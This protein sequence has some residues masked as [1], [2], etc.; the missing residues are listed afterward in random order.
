MEVMDLPTFDFSVLANATRNFSTENK[1]GEG[2]FGP[3][4]K[5]IKQTDIQNIIL[6]KN[7]LTIAKYYFSG[8]TGRWERVSCEKA[9]KDVW[10]RVR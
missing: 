3:V 5:V 9:F 10:T 4:Y 7:F 2:S 8:H 1:L 6:L